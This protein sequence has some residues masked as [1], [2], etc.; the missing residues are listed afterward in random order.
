M[1]IIAF[2]L[3]LTVLFATNGIAI[4]EHYCSMIDQEV[5]IQSNES[6]D[7]CCHTTYT[8]FLKQDVEGNVSQS[9][10]LEKSAHL[11]PQCL[12]FTH[13]GLN[14]SL[15]CELVFNIHPPPNLYLLTDIEPEQIQVFRC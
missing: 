1:R 5:P 2:V 4:G 8:D 10:S 9:I 6:D 12:L 3:S 14:E 13:I 7:N 11:L 15:S